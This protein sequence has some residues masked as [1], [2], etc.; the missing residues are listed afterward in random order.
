MLPL[1][2]ANRFPCIAFLCKVRLPL[3]VFLIMLGPLCVAANGNGRPPAPVVVE[4]ARQ[5]AL[6]PQTWVAGDVVS[7]NDARVAA[8]TPGR[9][10]WIAEVGARLRAGAILARLDGTTVKL[11]AAEFEAEVVREQARLRFLEQET[12][13]LRRLA[14]ENA[15]ARTR[16]DQTESDRDVARGDLAAAQARL[17]EVRDRLSRS[18]VL[19]PFAGVVSERLRRVGEWVAAGEAVARLVDTGSVEVVARAPLA[20]VSVVQAGQTVTLHHQGQAAEGGA[21]TDSEPSV[22][23]VRAVVPLGDERSRLL[24][25]RVE[26]SGAEWVA[27]MPVRVGVPTA[28]PRTVLAVPRDALVVRRDGVTVFRVNGESMAEPV[29]VTTG[30]AQG[31]W[32]EVQGGLQV[33]DSVVVRG[34]ERMRPGQKVRIV[35]GA[36]P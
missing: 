5:L 26:V 12:E 19:A 22:G 35:E 15:A 3:G 13:R 25:L 18:Q 28:L 21:S 7:R 4:Q 32:V 8:E 17:A 6:A 33:G 1:I 30:I 31:L 29:T 9:L 14:R 34:G 20:S 36:T 11:Q 27:G 10:I 23:V 2:S 24:E 16:L